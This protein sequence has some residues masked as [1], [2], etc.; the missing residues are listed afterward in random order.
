M[1]E[2]FSQGGKGSVGI[3]TNK[4]A[5]ARHFG[6][7]QS[8]VVYFAMGAE[9]S[10]YR[11]I[12]DKVSQRAYTLPD[13]I[14]AGTTALSLNTAGLLIHSGGSVDL[15]AL[16]VTRGEFFN[17]QGN[18]V[19]GA[20][21]HTKNDKVLIGNYWYRWDGTLPKNLPA[22]STIASGDVGVN[23]WM[24]VVDPGLKNTVPFSG[25][26]AINHN[27][28]DEGSVP[29]TAFEKFKQIKSS[30]DFDSKGG[31]SSDKSAS[32]NYAVSSFGNYGNGELYLDPGRHVVGE[33]FDNPY[34]VEFTGPGHI[35]KPN[36][37]GFTRINSYAD[38]NKYCFGAEYLYAVYNR[39][40]QGQGVIEGRVNMYLYGDS[41][42]HGGN[43]ERFALK[44]ENH[45]SSLFRSSGIPNVSVTNRAIPG[46]KVESL[47]TGTDL[48]PD[49]K[50][51]LIKYGVN[52]GAYPKDVRH[53][54]FMEQLNIKIGEIRSKPYGDLSNL[55]IILMGPNSTNDSVNG[56]DEE[57]YETIRGIY[58]SV[59]RKFQCVYFDTYALFRDAHGAAG[60][61]MDDPIADGTAIHPVDEGNM[62]IY[63]KLFDELF[64]A[65]KVSYLSTN[66]K[67][68][69]PGNIETLTPA[70]GPAGIYT[71]SETWNT[72]YA[73]NG[74]PVTGLCK[75][76]VGIDGLLS[77][78]IY[79]SASSRVL[80]R[81]A[82]IGNT[83]WNALTG[84]P[85]AVSLGNSW[86]NAGGNFHNPMVR[87]TQ[88]GT[89][90]LMGAIKSGVTT[91]GVAMF[92]VPDSAK[93][94]KT[95][96]HVVP[97]GIGHATAV[98]EITALGQCN[99][100]G[101]VDNALLVLDGITY[102]L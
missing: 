45:I 74:W 35:S 94:T 49:T 79:D 23:K 16:G 10:G 61:W 42:L 8:E 43:G 95:S 98:I 69:L 6:V 84:T 99:I 38:K 88:D 25:S 21:L 12:Y 101:G 80:H 64:S 52:D 47:N 58:A 53:R 63:G 39:M 55:S 14:S 68:N 5:V 7:K 50:L 85:Y 62:W 100:V 28:T 29:V 72:V 20:T 19:T 31:D 86:V 34:G 60:D 24:P 1:N 2:L 83:A 44:P 51:I 59:A 30:Q 93:P 91:A 57:W 26:H 56:R 32:L 22:G 82:N 3:L 96:R 9:L 27:L 92:S 67:W 41:T 70:Q 15:G 71:T 46:T 75:G 11:V 48:G 102:S 89:A 36:A 66:T 13:A 76:A 90:V 54:V 17:V 78:T 65:N 40:K 97:T 87:I 37:E 33:Y 81:S 18:S 77:Q 4:Q 73:V